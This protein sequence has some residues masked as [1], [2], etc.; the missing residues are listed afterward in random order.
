MIITNRD[1]NAPS[2]L[3]DYR[4]VMESMR[5]GM[6]RV[7]TEHSCVRMHTQMRARISRA[8]HPQIEIVMFHEVPRSDFP[9]F[10]INS[11]SRRTIYKHVGTAR[12]REREGCTK[13]PLHRNKCNKTLAN[14]K[15]DL[16]YAET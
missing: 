13:L 4:K 2:E 7:T 16:L 15:G 11:G 9:I 5:Q 8:S 10:G 14:K 6:L 12:E 1:C 3:Y